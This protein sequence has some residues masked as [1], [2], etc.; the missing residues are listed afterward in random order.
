[1]AIGLGVLRLAGRGR[2]AGEVQLDQLRPAELLRDAGERAIVDHLAVGV[3]AHHVAARDLRD[4]HAA[5][6]QR[7]IPVRR[8]E[9]IGWI[10]H[11]DAGLTVL[12][13]HPG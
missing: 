10:M 5:V 11:T 3:E 4:Q 13:H 7:R 12:A 8:G 2:L 1:M 9:C 6:R